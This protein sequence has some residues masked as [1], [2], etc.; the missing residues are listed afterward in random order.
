[1]IDRHLSLLYILPGTTCEAMLCTIVAARERMLEKVGRENIDKLVCMHLIKLIFLWKR[2]SRFLGLD[3]KI[4]ELFQQQ[5]ILNC[6][7][8][9]ITK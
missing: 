8:P 2:L 1:M 6:S 4:F 9:K 7:M 5:R 3:L